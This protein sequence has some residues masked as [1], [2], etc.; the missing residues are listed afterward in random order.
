MTNQ[1]VPT[2][3]LIVD[4]ADLAE[5]LRI[6]S[7]AMGRRVSGAYIRFEEGWVLVEGGEAVA[8]APAQGVWPFTI[9]VGA[10]W[11]RRLARSLPPGDPV[12]LHV[13]N[14][15]LY[16]NKYSEPCEWSTSEAPLNPSLRNIDIDR[17]I[18]EAA[19]V[20][21][22]FLVGPEDIRPLI[23]SRSKG[24]ASWREDE[25]PMISAVSKAWALLA[26]LGVETADLRNLVDVAVRDAW[27]GKKS[28]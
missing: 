21:K 16:A 3:G 20:L 23:E 2:E 19:A 24:P 5:A 10:S 6:V 25:E 22:P 17:R 11:V 13:E 12:F 15:R 27:K 18:S 4:R 7:H 1:P 28:T 9:V 26:P 14:G 8:K